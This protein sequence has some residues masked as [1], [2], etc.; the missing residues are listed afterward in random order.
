MA[1]GSV[2]FRDVA[3]D[4]SQEEWECLDPAQRDLYRDVMWETYSN[5]I[6]LGPSISKPDVITLLEEGKE[7]W[8]AV[9]EGAGKHGCAPAWGSIKLQELL[10]QGPLISEV[11]PH[12][13]TDLPDPRPDAVPGENGTGRI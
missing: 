7:P 11:D 6:S 12:I 8:M 5:F 13:C 1:H 2:T 4:F 3:V 10:V 9:R